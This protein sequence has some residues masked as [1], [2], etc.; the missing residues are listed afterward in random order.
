MSSSIGVVIPTFQAVKH[1]P[2]CLPP[3]IHSPLK[4]TILVIDSSSTDGTVEL[5]KTMGVETLTIPKHAFNHGTTREKGRQHLKTPIVVMMTQDAYPASSALLEQLVQPILH[6][7]AAAAYARQLPHQG[8]SL[9]AA[10][11][12]AFNYPPTSHLRS[13]ADIKTYGSY[14][15]FCSNSCAAYDQSALDAIGG[16][17]SV[18]FGEDTVV[19]AKLL[20]QRYRIAYVAEAQVYHSHDYT[21]KQEFCR[22]FDIG[23]ARRS[24]QDLLA[25]GGSDTSRGKNYV[26]ALLQDLWQKDPLRIPYA[27]LQTI[28]KFFGYRIGRACLKAPL[29]LKKA[30]SSQ[31]F[32]WDQPHTFQLE[33]I[34]DD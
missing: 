1:L 31:K 11:A 26:R 34:Q 7:Q 29:W 4:P 24:Y 21:L 19:V 17:P 18:L 22:H 10:F 3:L 28:A 8:A 15:F 16:F 33:K 13:L 23:L 14:T 6:R 27:C 25:I 5:A 20:H 12:R 9:F 2:L 32:Y 30:L